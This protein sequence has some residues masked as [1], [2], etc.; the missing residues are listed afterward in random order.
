NQFSVWLSKTG[1]SRNGND[2]RQT[3]P[4]ERRPS[5]P[6]GFPA[7]TADR[8]KQ[9]RMGAAPRVFGGNQNEIPSP[10]NP[11]PDFVVFG[12]RSGAGAN[13]RERFARGDE[14]TARTRAAELTR[15]AA[16]QSLQ[17]GQRH[18]PRAGEERKPRSLYG[19]FDH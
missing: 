13:F 3:K 15:L 8:S 12:H 11:S 1:G 7:G 14:T 4:W 17:R 18:S 9:A 2:I 19:R 5:S 10:F 16:A 6:A